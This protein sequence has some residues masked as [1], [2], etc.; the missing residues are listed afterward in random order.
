MGETGQVGAGQP[1]RPRIVAMQKDGHV[2][3]PVE[4]FD[5]LYSAYASAIL[6]YAARRTPSPQD[7]A[8][9]MAETFLVAWRRVGEVPDSED[10]RPWLYGVARHVLANHRRGDRRR[11]QLSERLALEL[12]LV[13]ED[14]HRVVEGPDL[15]SVR[16]ALDALREDDREL[17]LLVGWDGLSPAEAAA[18]LACSAG[19]VRVRL[20]RARRRLDAEL[21]RRGVQRDGDAGHGDLRRASARPDLGEL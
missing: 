9:V 13:V 16:V 18:V 19:T 15:S 3:D 20:H 2:A 21:L 12:A 11:S 10:A 5:E 17:L 1:E 4:R 6:A 8:D 14:A 7:A